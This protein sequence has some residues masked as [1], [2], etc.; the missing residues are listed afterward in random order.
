MV[1][2]LGKRDYTNIVDSAMAMTQHGVHLSS[3]FLLLASKRGDLPGLELV[4]K[5]D[6]SLSNVYPARTK[7]ITVEVGFKTRL[8]LISG[9][10]LSWK[11]GI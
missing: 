8:K 10:N 9:I 2:D 4:S 3:C 1:V 7:L 6:R 11:L 5:P